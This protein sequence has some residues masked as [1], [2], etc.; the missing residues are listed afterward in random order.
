[1]AAALLAP[2]AA[3]A[4]A[5]WPADGGGAGDGAGGLA[6]D[7]E[8]AGDDAP[9]EA[10]LGDEPIEV[11]APG[12]VRIRL[13]ERDGQVC[14]DVEL[15]TSGSGVCGSSLR[16]LVQHGGFGG[17]S[18]G[19]TSTIDVVTLVGPEVASAVAVHGDGDE[20][21][22]ELVAIPGRVE[23]VVV[24]QIRAAGDVFAR[25]GG[26]GWSLELRDEGGDVI[27]SFPA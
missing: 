10:P 15:A 27:E 7:E 26:S 19:R 8:V 23:Q 22:M 3:L 21:A 25:P 13:S 5:V 1:M 4:A 6:A 20:L 14:M 24:G 11:D 16:D 18:D 17:S 2:P 9:F 12:G